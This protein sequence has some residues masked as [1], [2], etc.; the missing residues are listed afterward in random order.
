MTNEDAAVDEVRPEATP[1]LTG[2]EL[3]RWYWL[4]SELVA[5]ARQLG[6]PTGGGKQELTRRVVAA[7]DGLPAPEATSR[8]PAPRSGQLPGPLGRD[9]VIPP[10]QRSSQLL[11]QF[12]EH[13]LGPSFSFDARMRAFIAEGGHT[14]DQAL[15]FWRSGRGRRPNRE[16]G[17]QF[18]LN[19]FLR[20][21]HTSHPGGPR[22]EAVA[23]WRVHRDT[24][25]DRRDD[26]AG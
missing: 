1:T 21:W 6:V 4:K 17:A 7:L 18:E 14:L 24:P 22:S 11:R 26:V 13:E 10:G 2:A 25:V 23:A 3:L 5:L 8:D 20:H 9:T 16:I 19:A 15:T 12:F